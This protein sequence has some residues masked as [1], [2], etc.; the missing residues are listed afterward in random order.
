MALVGS[1]GFSK[2]GAVSVIRL[3]AEFVQA[4][5][6]REEGGNFRQPYRNLTVTPPQPSHCASEHFQK[7]Y[8]DILKISNIYTTANMLSE[9]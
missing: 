8:L 3:D 9:R 1:T 5:V 4:G 6:G 2:W 7:K